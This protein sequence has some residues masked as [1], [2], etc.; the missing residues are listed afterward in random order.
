MGNHSYAI[1]V[2]AGCLVKI[3]SHPIFVK[4][5]DGAAAGLLEDSYRY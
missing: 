3:L 5:Q 4:L 1:Y 2:A